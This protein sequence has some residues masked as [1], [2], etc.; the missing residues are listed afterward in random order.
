[1]DNV[2]TTV[3]EV[4]RMKAMP[5]ED[6]IRAIE[7]TCVN[8]IFEDGIQTL[9]EQLG[10]EYYYDRERGDFSLAKINESREKFLGRMEGWS[11]EK[12]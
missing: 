4:I 2:L 9:F 12:L 6:L 8:T 3:K 10:D 1:M 11:V 5:K 7:L